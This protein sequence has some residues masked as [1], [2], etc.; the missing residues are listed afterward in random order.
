ME[1]KRVRVT[2][3]FSV[4]VLLA[5]GSVS[6]A[7]IQSIN[8]TDLDTSFTASSG[9]LSILNTADIVVE[10]TLGQQ[11]TYTQGEFD[12]STFLQTDASSGGL[13]IGYFAEG[14]LSFTDSDSN[15]LL[16]GNIISIDIVELF[17]GLGMLA[18]HGQ[19]E[20][21]GGT[22]END[23]ALP[24]GEIVQITFNVSP[25]SIGDFTADF[26]GSSNITVVPVPEPATICLLGLGALGLLRRRK[27]S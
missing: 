22:L 24:Y 5:A 17:D 6:H 26:T 15:A 21:T 11:T 25:A 19:F 9:V 16:T 27:S 12:L 8:A 10:N 13:A 4:M 18:G 1:M 14:Y 7:T 3:L 2:V 23:F 20:V